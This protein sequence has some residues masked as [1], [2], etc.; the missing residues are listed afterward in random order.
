MEK[1]L[2]MAEARRALNKLPEHF[3][4]SPDTST[5]AVTRR[6]RPVLAVLP[7]DHYEAL[8]ETLEVLGDE[9]QTNA[10]RQAIAECDAGDSVPWDIAEDT[11]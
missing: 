1:M 6:G 3:V 11:P 8:M 4:E 9:A 5:V 10:L 7:W 2:S